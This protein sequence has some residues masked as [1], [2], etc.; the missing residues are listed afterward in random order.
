MVFAPWDWWTAYVSVS[1]K[2][3]CNSNFMFD[4]KCQKMFRFDI[5]MPQKLFILLNI[6]NI[7]K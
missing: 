3:H 5:K 1:Q 7:S 2:D 4:F 6:K